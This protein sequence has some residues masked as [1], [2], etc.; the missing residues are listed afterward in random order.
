M[1]LSAMTIQGLWEC[2]SPLL[3][4]PYIGEEHMRF[5]MSKKRHIKNLQQ[6]AQLK[7][8]EQRHILKNLNDFEYANVMKVL[9][10]MPLIDFNI[11]VE[12]I[13]DEN[14]NVV[15]AGAIVTVTVTLK[16]RSMRELFGDS[17]AVEKQGIR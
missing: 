14:T 8:D 17:T 13:D 9:G 10:R 11:N 1:K 12:V 2:K 6:F 3:Q 5:F 7:V 16:R 15:T 4:L